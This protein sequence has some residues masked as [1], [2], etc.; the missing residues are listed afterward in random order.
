MAIKTK[1]ISDLTNIPLETKTPNLE[2]L[3]TLDEGNFYLLGC[4]NNVTGK[5]STKDVADTIRGIAIQLIEQKVESDSLTN[6][7]S[8]ISE[9]VIDELK[10]SSAST[11]S[12]ILTVTQK[13]D[14][15]D[16]KYK[17][18]SH[19]FTQKYAELQEKIVVLEE[20]LA[21]ANSKIE[22]LEKFVHSLQEDGY[23]TLAKIKQAAA[24]TCPCP[25][26]HEQ[27]TE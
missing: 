23:L 13:L 9:E 21:S 5:V 12:S 16:A 7:P 25:E 3:T 1:K 20:T 6:K 8:V 19:S 27:P 17:K 11:S 2:S 15:V 10:A 26:T 18:L 22:A 24:D 14:D 4:Y